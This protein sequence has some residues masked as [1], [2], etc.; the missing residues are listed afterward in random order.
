MTGVTNS[1]NKTFSPPWETGKGGKAPSG[2]FGK[3]GMGMGGMGKGP[4]VGKGSLAHL[5]TV[6][7]TNPALHDARSGSCVQRKW[8]KEV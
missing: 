6:P 5:G 8:V 2:G 1:Y 3:G 7:H 4:T